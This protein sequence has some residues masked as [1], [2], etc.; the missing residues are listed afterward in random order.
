MAEPAV[1]GPLA[2]RHLDRHLGPYP[3]GVP[4]VELGRLGRERA[5]VDG[6]RAQHPLHPQQ[7]GGGEARADPAAVAQLGCAGR[8]VDPDEQ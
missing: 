7:L 1:V 2:V 8:V 3:V 6:Q 5:L 4:H